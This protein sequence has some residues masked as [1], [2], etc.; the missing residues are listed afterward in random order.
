MPSLPRM[1]Q[2]IHLPNKPLHTHPTLH[3]ILINICILLQRLQIIRN[4]LSAFQRGI[5]LNVKLQD[6]VLF[7]HIFCN[8]SDY[9]IVVDSV[10]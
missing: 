9:Y 2:N 6:I 10:V 7:R 5:I 4:H 8:C 1:L 3:R